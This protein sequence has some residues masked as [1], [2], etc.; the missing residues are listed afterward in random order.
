MYQS[1]I[2]YFGTTKQLLPQVG[3]VAKTQIVALAKWIDSPIDNSAQG[4]ML[5]HAGCLYLPL[6]GL[7]VT[8]TNCAP[9]LVRTEADRIGRMLL[10]DMILLRCGAEQGGTL[11]IKLAHQ[12]SW[13][14]GYLP[15]SCEESLWFIPCQPDYPL[16]EVAGGLFERSLVPFSSAAGRSH[17][18]ERAFRALAGLARR[19]I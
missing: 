15:W 12:E 4:R 17:G 19:S 14:A 18:I 11:E 9:P 16:F 8:A 10:C 7:A 13:L 3:N 5:A 1:Q 2:D 6:A